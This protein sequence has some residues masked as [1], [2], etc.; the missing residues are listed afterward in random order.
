VQ[1][2]AWERDGGQC[3]FVGRNGHRCTERTF[4]EFHHVRPHAWRGEPTAENIWLRCRAHNVYES[5]MI[6]GP[7]DP[8][9]VRETSV[10]YGL[11]MSGNLS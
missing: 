6:F 10:D 9:V 5:E 1:R 2:A 11:S 4:L 8:S 7:F 3:A